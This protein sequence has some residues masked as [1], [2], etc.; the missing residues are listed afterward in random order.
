MVAAR[1]TVPAKPFWLVNV[2]VAFPDDP[3]TML[4]E[5][6]S[7]LI[8]KSGPTTVT[9]TFAVWEFPPP[10][11]LTDT[12]YVPGVVEGPTVTLRVVVP[13]EDG[14]TLIMELLRVAVIPVGVLGEEKV[15]AP[16]NPFKLET[17]T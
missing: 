4:S 9:G 5:D 13:E 16:E 15:T 17:V 8:E 7:R 3:T 10:D 14:L 12:V 6:W 11:P 2:T 1:F